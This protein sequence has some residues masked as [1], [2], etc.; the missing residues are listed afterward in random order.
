MTLPSPHS[1][2]RSHPSPRSGS[3]P[4]FAPAALLL[5]PL[6]VPLLAA[7]CQKSP[8]VVPVHQE[9]ESNDT[10]ASANHMGVLGVGDR[11]FIEG[12]I[13][14]PFVDIDGFSFVSA[15]PIH[16]DFQLFADRDLD[17]CLYDPALDATVACFA[18]ANHPERGGVDVFAG[19]LEFH[20]TVE[21]CIEP[22]CSPAFGTPYTLELT[23]QH[24]FLATTE[25]G[26]EAGSASQAL[27]DTGGS[28]RG[29]EATLEE[30]RQSAPRS[31]GRY[32][33]RERAD[34]AVPDLILQTHTELFFDENTDTTFLIETRG[35]LSP[36]GD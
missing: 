14:D 22:G 18:T 16:V 8:Q 12:V 13:G 1:A 33:N 31:P 34:E 15:S 11:L 17:V 20:L 32:R 26:A 27:E 9:Q 7:A 10:P 30:G 3:H 19:G 5:V 35:A 29:V 21:A 28:V 4:P 6:L 23:V 36:R 25:N 24:L 2:T